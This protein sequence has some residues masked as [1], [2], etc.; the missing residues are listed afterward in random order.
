[1]TVGAGDYGVNSCLC[2][3]DVPAVLERA[4]VEWDDDFET[5]DYILKM[6]PGGAANGGRR[7]DAAQC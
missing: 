6:T 3:I 4:G 2:V 7:E 1:M 5:G